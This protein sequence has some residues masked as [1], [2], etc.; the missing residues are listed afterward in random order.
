MQETLD[1]LAGLSARLDEEIEALNAR[2]DEYER[3]LDGA[4]VRVSAE[5]AVGSQW[6]L[7]YRKYKT[8]WR[9]VASR[10]NEAWRPLRDTPLEA[11]ALLT[12]H[13]DRLFPV[14]ERKLREYLESTQRALRPA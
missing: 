13:I 1:R 5:V 14:L 6:R 2:I 3:G 8:G 7:G 9:V 12:L 4:G 10:E 11:R